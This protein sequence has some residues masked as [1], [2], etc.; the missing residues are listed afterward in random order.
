MSLDQRFAESMGQLLGPDFPSDIALAV[1]GGGDSMAMLYL[2]HNW[3]RVWGV[4]L[5]VVTVDHG[6]RA[7]SAAEAA[8]VAGEC[9]ALGWPHDVLRWSW[10]GAGNVMDAAR[11]AR[12]DLID[13]WRGDIRHVLMAHTQDDVAE[14]FLMRVQRGAGVEGLAAMSA[15]RRVPQ[16]FDVV[17]PCLEMR[18]AELR[19]YL[20]VLHGPWV[21]DPTNED[22]KYDRA[23]IRRLIAESDL[24]VSALA[25][26]AQ[27]MSRAR[28]A[29]NARAVEVWD[30]IGR[31]DFGTLVIDRAG[32]AGVEAETQMRLLAKGLQFVASAEYRPRGPAME[33]L[34]DR[35]T[36]G[37]STTL[38][39][40]EIRV[41]R[42]SLR[43][44][45]EYNAVA[46]TVAPCDG[47]AVWDRRWHVVAQMPGHEVRA[48]GDEGWRQVADKP[49][50]APPFAFA[51]SLPAV[52]RGAELA[53][54][55]PL[56]VGETVLSVEDVRFRDYLLSH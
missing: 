53:H 33:A 46:G 3:T 25:A 40:C 12:L 45:R 21:E 5:H 17:R 26:T 39:G 11:R 20:K 19:H 48:L 36:A 43:I 13:R 35:V 10:D 52:W 24:D 18:R 49:A 30:R 32:F 54:C 14:T 50:G 56:G 47:G 9:R 16:G 4:R 15:T 37:G 41:G 23:R 2:A 8:M 22:P 29:L 34:L 28:V 51:R 44:F 38:H 27:S 31:E 1:S 6:L 55:A 7:E 42:D